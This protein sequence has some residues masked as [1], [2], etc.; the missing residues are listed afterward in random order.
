MSKIANWFHNSRMRAKTSM[1]PSASPLNQLSS[2]ALV[3]QSDD[4]DDFVDNNNNPNND[5][6]EDDDADSD[7]NYS[8]LPTIVPLT[9]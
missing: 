5:E 6:D 7:E 2:S 4:E 1:R 9:R 3:Q 8:G